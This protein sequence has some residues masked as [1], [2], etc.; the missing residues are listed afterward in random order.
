M[1]DD[2][3]QLGIFIY[4]LLKQGKQPDD[5]YPPYIMLYANQT[6]FLGA[7]T[8]TNPILS[9]LTTNGKQVLDAFAQMIIYDASL[10]NYK[11]ELNLTGTNSNLKIDPDTGQV[12]EDI[13]LIA[14]HGDGRKFH[15]IAYIEKVISYISIKECKFNISLNTKD[16]SQ[17]QPVNRGNYVQKTSIVH[18]SPRFGGSENPLEASAPVLCSDQLMVIPAGTE[19]N[20]V[21]D[22]NQ[23]QGSALLSGYVNLAANSNS[24]MLSFVQPG[25][26]LVDIPIPPLPPQFS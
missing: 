22:K 8:Q 6:T 7:S 20:L 4:Q 24:I 16:A 14:Y 2:A 26:S 1:P 15:T 21:N 3:Q 10:W 12:T 19:V 5:A 25:L 13:D 11:F 23:S 17:I 18:I 9:D